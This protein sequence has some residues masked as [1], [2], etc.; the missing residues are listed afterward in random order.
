MGRRRADRVSGTSAALLPM[1]PILAPLLVCVGACS[2]AWDALEP[3]S[4]T[5]S[6]ASSAGSGGG[7]TSTGSGG[8]AASTTA[9]GA[10]SSSA[11]GAGSGGGT[12]S[13]SGAGGGGPVHCA[14]TN[15]LSWDFTDD[16]PEIFDRDAEAAL[17]GGHG[18]I[19]LPANASSYDGGAFTTKRAYDLRGDRVFIEVTQVPNQGQGTYGGLELDYDNGDDLFLGV[20]GGKLECGFDHDNNESLPMQQAYDPVAHRWW[21]LREDQGTIHC[22]T[23][24]DGATWSDAGS[25]DVGPSQLAVP[26]AVRVQLYAETPNAKS[27]PGAF[28]FDNLNGATPSTG[29]WCKASSYTD[30]FDDLPSV[31]GP[32]W[33]RSYANNGDSYDQMG[34]TLNLHW[35]SNDSS[36]LGYASTV[37]YDLTGERVTV[38]ILQLPSPSPG[39]TYF[40]IGN[41]DQLDVY[42]VA[43]QG[44]FKC[45][46]ENTGGSHTIWQGLAP[47]LPAW[48]GLRESG[49][50]IYCEI[51]EGGTWKSYGSIGGVVDATA[52]DVFLGAYAYSGSMPQ[53][54]VSV[55]D[56][57]NQAPVP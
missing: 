38:E 35:G 15:L 52:V 27:M 37:A 29:S 21:Q 31:P 8:G 32:A 41:A 4:S 12:T 18:F 51:L 7:G 50:K 42:W 6:G 30:D 25:F 22:E 45:G 28:A 23:S 53:D 40:S 2:H 14:G 16:Q 34:D 9:T 43:N 13:S 48:I 56:G 54:S 5:S 26:S 46:Y 44:G 57:Y 11:G 33:D 10:S 3:V 20:Y 49:G 19:N 24:P 39:D 36:N 17:M 55:F 1:L 47:A